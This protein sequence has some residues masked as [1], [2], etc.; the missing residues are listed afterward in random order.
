MIK[1]SYYWNLKCSFVPFFL[2][3]APRAVCVELAG[4]A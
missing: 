3:T 1:L 2:S 4:S